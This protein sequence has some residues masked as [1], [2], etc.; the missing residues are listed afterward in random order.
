MV[1]LQNLAKYRRYLIQDA[2]VLVVRGG[3]KPVMEGMKA[4]NSRHGITPPPDTLIPM[5]QELLAATVL[6]ALSLA[7]RE[8]WGW[9]LTFQGMRTGFFV[10]IEPEGMICLRVR[11]ADARKASATVQRQKAGLPMTQSHITPLTTSPRD[12]VEQYFAEAVQVR[13]RLGVR[14]DGESVL[15]QAL[16]GSRF[17]A[18]SESGPDGLFNFVE[19]AAAEGRAKELGEALIFYEC[20]CSEALIHRMLNGLQEAEKDDLFGDQTHV[21]IECPRCGRKFEVARTETII[22]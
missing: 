18:V 19:K 22:H 17:N 7:D 10:G 21:G 14:A 5:I 4:Y 12:L 16:P 8:S 6:A 13:T 1:G 11:D 9:S 20:R 15:V 3:I 2:N